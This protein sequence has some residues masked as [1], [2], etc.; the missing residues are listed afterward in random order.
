MGSQLL[1]KQFVFK[2]IIRT[3]ADG[4]KIIYFLTQSDYEVIEEY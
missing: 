1:G 4:K 2:I 3:F